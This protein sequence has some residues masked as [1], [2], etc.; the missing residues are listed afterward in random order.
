MHWQGLAEGYGSND[1]MVSIGKKGRVV[2]MVCHSDHQYILHSPL[3]AIVT[4]VPVH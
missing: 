3:L 1:S 2:W 4:L